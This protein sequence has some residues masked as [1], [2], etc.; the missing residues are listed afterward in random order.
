MREELNRRLRAGQLGPEILPWVNSLPEVR[1]VIDDFF[2]GQE[3]NPQNLSDWRNGGFQDWEEKQDKTHRIK[4]LASFAVKLTEANG[5]R[6]AEGAA[7]IA[8]GKVLEL[9]ESLE[10][11]PGE[12][13]LERL[14]EVIAAVSSL[15]AGDIAQHR[16]G[17]DQAKLRQKDQ[18]LALARER[19]QRDTC[20]LFVKWATDQRAL[21]LAA[22]PLS[23]ETK[24]EEMGKLMFGE[25]WEKAKG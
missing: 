5:G 20:E 12:D 17:I 2:G 1:K 10:G 25:L 23:N 11:Q 15:R 19:F 14:G 21:Q 8:S 9:L 7:A 3:I 6:I 13:A 24:I 22:A 18:E 4:E 16:A